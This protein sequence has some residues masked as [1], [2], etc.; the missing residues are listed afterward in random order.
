MYPTSNM[1]AS[2]VEAIRYM[3]DCARAFEAA[4]KIAIRNVLADE[5]GEEWTAKQFNAHDFDRYEVDM[6]SLD[7]LLADGY[8]SRSMEEFELPMQVREKIASR[9]EKVTLDNGEVITFNLES[10]QDP[11]RVGRHLRSW[12]EDSPIVTKV[13]RGP[14][15][16]FKGR[17]YVYRLV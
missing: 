17:R 15:P 13:E 16:E 2:T 9:T 10:W 11:H 8:I 1:K 6:P 12:D 4:R 7:T 5:L 14:L 3:E